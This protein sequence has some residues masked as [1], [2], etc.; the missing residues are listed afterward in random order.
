MLFIIS[1]ALLLKNYPTKIISKSLVLINYIFIKYS[2]YYNAFIQIMRFT[3]QKISSL[4]IT[5]T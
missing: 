1:F 2:N 5:G 4:T 3:G